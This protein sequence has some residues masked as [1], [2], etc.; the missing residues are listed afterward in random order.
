MKIPKYYYTYFILKNYNLWQLFYFGRTLT[1]VTT[2]KVTFFKNF[3]CS[4]NFSLSN[5]FKK[6]EI[7][8]NLFLFQ[9]FLFYNIKSIFG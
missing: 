3:Q 7:T 8:I 2:V 1:E 6:K 5:N 4:K 9:F